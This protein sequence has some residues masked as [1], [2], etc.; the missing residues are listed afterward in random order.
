[1]K[2][3]TIKKARWFWPWQD[4]QEESWLS[5]MSKKGWHLQSVSLPCIYT[6]G[7]GDA[8]AYTYR[9]DYM[10]DSEA[11]KPE[12]QQIFR[13]A[14]WDYLG[15]MSNWR[16]WR[17]L[18]KPGEKAEIFSDNE[19]KLRKY[20]RLLGYMVFFLFLLTYLGIMVWRGVGWASTND[21]PVVA[22]IYQIG[23]VL[24]AVII[25]VYIVVVFQIWR[26]V[27]QLQQTQI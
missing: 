19:S 9:L 15:E 3:S 10:P 26:R 13:D 12:Y 20:K 22:V 4:E 17:K 24:Y 8:L 25:P 14:G 16:Y 21:L 27:K 11:K 1:M 23:A 2:S 7:S 18:P 5:E 6:F